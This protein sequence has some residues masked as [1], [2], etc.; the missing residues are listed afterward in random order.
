MVCT[1][2]VYSDI[3]SPV[4]TIASGQIPLIRAFYT[5]THYPWLVQTHVKEW[6]G[7]QFTGEGINQA[8]MEKRFLGD[9]HF[10]ENLHQIYNESRDK[11]LGYLEQTSL[12]ASL[13]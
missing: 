7:R 1:P 5:I 2:P 3:N 11:A 6:L 12:Q 9:Y 10:H 8:A 4:H 13:G